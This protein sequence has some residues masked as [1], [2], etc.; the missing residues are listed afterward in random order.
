MPEE[1]GNLTALIGLGLIVWTAVYAPIFLLR[2][3]RGKKLNKKKKI[4][5]SPILYYIGILLSGGLSIESFLSGTPYF[6]LIFILI[7]L[8][9]IVCLFLL[10]KNKE[11]FR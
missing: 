4:N 6:G 2:L 5:D 8:V 3:L 9:S 7:F 10:K 1:L 11:K